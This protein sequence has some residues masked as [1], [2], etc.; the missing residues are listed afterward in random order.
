MKFSHN[1]KT[2]Y[3]SH[4]SDEEKPHKCHICPK[5]FITA[6]QL[7]KHLKQHEKNQLKQHVQRVKQ[8]VKDEKEQIN[9]YNMKPEQWNQL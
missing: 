8:N 7:K 4:V 9:Y 2:H 6:P 5:A 1:W 3:L